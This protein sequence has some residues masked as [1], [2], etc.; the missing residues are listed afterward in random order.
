MCTG[1]EVQIYVFADTMSGRTI[2]V[3]GGKEHAISI[4][5]ETGV[6]DF[7]FSLDGSALAVIDYHGDILLWALCQDTHFADF[8]RTSKLK[9]ILTVTGPTLKYSLPSD[10]NPCSI[11]FLELGDEDGVAPY[12][13]LVLVGSSYNR[14]LHLVNIAE[15][16][17]LQE[18]IL[19]SNTSEKMPPQN[20]SMTFIKE[21]QI[22]TL[23]DTLSNSIYF[24]HLQSSSLASQLAILQSDFITHIAKSDANDLSVEFRDGIPPAF[25]FVVELPFFQHHQLQTLVTTLS[26]DAHLDVFTAHSNGFTMLSPDKDDI[27]PANYKKAEQA[28]SKP[29]PNPYLGRTKVAPKSHDQSLSS[30]SLSRRSSSESLQDRATRSAFNKRRSTEKMKNK[31]TPV[32]EAPMPMKKSDSEKSSPEI[33]APEPVLPP[34]VEN[35]KPKPPSP[36]LPPTAESQKEITSLAK[37]VES[38]LNQAL[39]QQCITLG[40][41]LTKFR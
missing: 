1:L 28:P 12:T 38:I 37:D 31:D 19:P 22:L 11:R 20:F 4:P 2:N 41:A 23:G 32:V 35:E 36:V 18:I 39:D 13:P 26:V 25:D 40:R 5:V 9:G 29:L 17:L 33:E 3:S 8:Y 30:R 21:K 14:R 34:M 24:I 10:L 15:G 27:L 16:K 7:A 6:R